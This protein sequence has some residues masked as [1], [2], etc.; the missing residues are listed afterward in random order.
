MID[1]AAFDNA[2]GPTQLIETA[3]RYATQLT[4]DLAIAKS[5]MWAALAHTAARYSEFV[6]WLHQDAG[7]T[8]SGAHWT[9][10]ALSLAHACG[11]SGLVAYALMRRSNQAAE[12]S[13][14]GMALGL[15]E[16]ALG[17]GGASTARIRAL[18]YRQKAAGLALAQDRVGCAE[19]LSRAREAIAADPQW[20]PLTG[21]CT[22]HY[23]DAEAAV[24]HL[25]L[26]QVDRAVE[27]LAPA[28]DSW[29]AGYVRDRGF[30]QAHFAEAL[31]RAG[32]LD[33][34]MA[35]ARQAASL[36]TVTESGRTFAQIKHVLHALETRGSTGI[37]TDLRLELAD[38]LE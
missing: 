15:A 38:A 28:I 35:H 17:T 9:E 14:T 7:D 2:N 11:D 32:H 1:F 16:A 22:L 3:S 25:R 6:G 18:G 34:G 5:G 26:G 12:Q 30:Y 27:L 20:N 29:S 23:L 36:A 8:T 37:A 24:C 13:E 31:I 33:E 4:D 19:A 10:Q 21:Y